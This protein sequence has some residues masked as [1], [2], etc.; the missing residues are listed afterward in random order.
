MKMSTTNQPSLTVVGKILHKAKSGRLI[1]KLDEKVEV[2]NGSMLFNSTG[3]KI[4]KI[5]E[6]IGPVIS[7][8]ASVIL[9]DDKLKV[10]QGDKIFKSNLKTIYTNDH[11][12][13]KKRNSRGRS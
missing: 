4:G 7:P 2:N 9:L 5:N 12:K 1:V 3:H 11:R 10:I 8:Y 13:I 6:L